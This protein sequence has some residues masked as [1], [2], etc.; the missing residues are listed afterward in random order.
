MVL[1]RLLDH[2]L[3]LPPH[4]QNSLEWV[5]AINLVSAIQHMFHWDGSHNEEHTHVLVQE[6]LDKFVQGN[7]GSRPPDPGAAVDQDCAR[8]VTKHLIL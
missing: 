2:L 3:P 6:V 7:E 8:S 5:Q 4:L 1:E